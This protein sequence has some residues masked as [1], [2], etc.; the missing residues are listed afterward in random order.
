MTPVTTPGSPLPPPPGGWTPA[1]P[2]RSSSPFALADPGLLTPPPPAV[3][4]GAEPAGHVPAAD[5]PRLRTRVVR[6]WPEIAVVVGAVVL[7]G[8]GL[9]K[10]GYGNDYYAAAARSMTQSWSNF[11]YAA[12]DPGGWITVDKPPLAFWLQA[13]SARVFGYS[14]WALLLPSVLCGAAAV[15]LLM[16]AVRRA[17]GRAAGLVAGIALAFTPVLLAVSRSNNPDV[18]LV[19]CMVAAGYATQRAITD[20][21]PR[22]LYLAGLFIGLAFL[23]KLLVALLIVPGLW[24]AYLVTGPSNWR[25]RIGHLALATLVMVGV[26]GAWV[27]SVDLTP[28]TSRPYIGGSVNGNALDLVLG[29][30][31]I[32]R[33]TGNNRG[34]PAAG[35]ARPAASAV[36]G[37]TAS[38]SSAGRPASP[39]C[40]TTGWATR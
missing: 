24:L 28:V 6:R 32:G 22:W 27:V 33:V 31:G 30:N 18:T 38:T 17:W 2:G 4:P 13:L 23:A 36:A 11:F 3:A 35:A 40:S 12:F 1:E 26:S 37:R 39:G 7:F 21:K 16:A 19:L 20:R 9:G 8:W 15:A 29:Y 5:R 14:A 10:N 25:R 34:Q